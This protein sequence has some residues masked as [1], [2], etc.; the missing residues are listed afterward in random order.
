MN[1]KHLDPGDFDVNNIGADSEFGYKAD[2]K[3][4]VATIRD[5]QVRFAAVDPENVEGY[6]VVVA[7]LDNEENEIV[8]RVEIGGPP[9]IRPLLIESLMAALANCR[10]ADSE[11][12]ATAAAKEGND[13]PN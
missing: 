1:T 5:I 10:K 7:T 4:I 6:I 9:S 12:D 13:G 11:Y 3:D 8:T 2:I